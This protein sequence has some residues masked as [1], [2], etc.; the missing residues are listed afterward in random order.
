MKNI[1]LIGLMLLSI[2][3]S[4]CGE[5]P[6]A[7]PASVP[8]TSTESQ[9]T[10]LPPPTDTPPAASPT[11]A[12]EPTQAAP[13]VSFANDV[14]PILQVSCIECHGVRQ[15][16]EGLDLQTYETLLA[17]SFNGPVILPGSAS[18]SL[19]VQLVVEGEMPNRGPKL[20]AEQIQLISEWINAG[21]PN[22]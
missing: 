16:K 3:I 20:T 6:Q 10:P 12:V 9:P 18:E 15:V 21:A 8:P 7:A 17:G 14:M 4:A 13:S 22:N 2:F 11:V 19:L 1:L 5:T